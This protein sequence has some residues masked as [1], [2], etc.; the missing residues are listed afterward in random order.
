MVLSCAIASTTR[1]SPSSSSPGPIPAAPIAAA[2]TSPSASSSIYKRARGP[3]LERRWSNR[4]HLLQVGRPRQRCVHVFS[5][6]CIV[7][8][9]VLLSV[10]GAG[11]T[12]ICPRVK[13]VLS[14]W[15]EL[16]TTPS[17]PLGLFLCSLVGGFGFVVGKLHLFIVNLFVVQVR[18]VCALEVLQWLREDEG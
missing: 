12:T 10:G 7:V 8:I 1:S 11:S 14:P 4:H 6:F 17:T 18:G 13:I 3:L 2:S 5:S 15:L 9:H 16:A